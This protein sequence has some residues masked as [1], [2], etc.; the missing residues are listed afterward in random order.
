MQF[1]IGLVGN[2]LKTRSGG[3]SGVLAKIAFLTIVMQG[4]V[5][6]LLIRLFP[7]QLTIFTN[8]LAIFV[9]DS[10]FLN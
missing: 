5:A 1:A 10:L 8:R 9:K 3:K 6:L 2:M 4:A 7:N